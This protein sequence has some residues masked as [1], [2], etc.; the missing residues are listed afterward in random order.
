MK[1]AYLTKTKFRDIKG[2]HAELAKFIQSIQLPPLALT[3]FESLSKEA[4]INLLCISPVSVAKSRNGYYVVGGIRQYL[5]AQQL[6]T[7]D[8]TIPVLKYDSRI[9]IKSMK[10]RLLV[11][12]FHQPLLLGLCQSDTRTIK[13]ILNSLDNIDSEL[14]SDLEIATK[15]T[16]AFWGRVSERTLARA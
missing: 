12:I 3:Y 5:A 14:L 6:L 15:F 1:L 9:D 8:E 2:S 16:Q 4:L 11:E 13:S 10:K 7:Q